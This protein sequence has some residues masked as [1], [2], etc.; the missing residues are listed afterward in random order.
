M[1]P[2]RPIPRHTGDFS[3]CGIRPKGL[4]FR[5]RTSAGTF[6]D[7][8]VRMVRV[9]EVVS[10]QALGRMGRVGRLSVRVGE[11]MRPCPIEVCL[12]VALGLPI[13][14]SSVPGVDL[15]GALDA[16]PGSEA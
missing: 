9:A 11:V 16:S 13:S 2:T 3:E 12:P 6:W 8:P 5:P 7:V 4:C 14:D 10:A 1:R 15:V